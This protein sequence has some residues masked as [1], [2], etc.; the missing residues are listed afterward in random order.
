MLIIILSLL[1]TR[2]S[3][4]LQ[5]IVISLIYPYQINPSVSSLFI[6]IYNLIKGLVWKSTSLTWTNPWI[7]VDA[8]NGL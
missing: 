7:L 4:D 8:V 2:V 3:W 6:S 5:K 1:R